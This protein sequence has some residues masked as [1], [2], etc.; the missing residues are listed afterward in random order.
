VELASGSDEIRIKYSRALEAVGVEAHIKNFTAEG[1]RPRARLV[2]RLG[3]EEAE[4]SIRLDKDNAVVLYFSTANRKEAERRAAVLRAVGVRAEVKKTYHKSLKRDVWQMAVTTNALA[5]D[6]VHEAVRRAVAEFL[7]KCREAGAVGEDTYRRLAAKIERG[8]PE[9]GDIRFSLWLKKDGAVEVVYEPSDPESFSKAVELL[10]GLDMRDTCEGGWCIVHFTAKEPRGGKRG[11]VRITADGLRYIGWLALHGDERAQRLKEMLLKEAEAKG[12]G[13]RQR[14]EEYYR[15]GEMWGSVRPPIE[16][17][18]E[19][20]GRR[21][22]VRVEAVEAWREQGKTKEHLVV[23]VRARVEEERRETTVEKEARFFKTSG[24]I[25]GYVN[26]HA[27]A[28]GGPEADYIRTAAVLKTL[29]VEKWRRKPKQILLTGG[30]LDVLMRL[31]PV[32]G[33]L[34]V[35]QKA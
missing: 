16:K 35:C 18:V 6:P 5:A 11:F 23:K 30:A 12:E 20:D 21:V 3:G 14:L 19:L 27:D 15:E 17:E 1:G 8:V 26:I 32:C 2:V 22:R 25:N 24:K 13:V 29:G 28:G 7:E 9:W 31:E 33:A 34:G 10:R 4:Y